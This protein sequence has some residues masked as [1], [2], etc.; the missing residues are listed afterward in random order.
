MN[1][2][3]W[4]K[5]K[6]IAVVGETGSGKTASCFT[7]MD[8][9]KDRK[10]FI[11]NHPTPHI[12]TE[13]GI[14]NIPDLSMDSMVDCALWI[15]EPQLIYPKYQKKNNDHLLMLYSLARQRDITLIVSTSDTRWINKGMEAYVDTWLI[16]NLD[17]DLVKQGSVIKKI[18]SQK[19][20]NIIP[21]AF[22]LD[23]SEAILYCKNQLAQP[24]KIN[25]PLP[26]YWSEKFSKPY[27]FADT[28]TLNFFG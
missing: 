26:K 2:F 16:K 23:S 5:C 4:N 24:H 6:L 8:A 20:H 9:I 14:E 27:K 19:Y 22:K 21:K 7:I 11:V 17:F 1:E 25:I 18:I 3:N 12:L 28:E 10:K 15:D 13:S